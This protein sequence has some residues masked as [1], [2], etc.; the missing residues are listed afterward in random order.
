MRTIRAFQGLSVGFLI[1][2]GDCAKVDMQ[3]YQPRDN[4]CAGNINHCTSRG[5]R[6]TDRNNAPVLYSDGYARR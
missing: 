4:R 2:R 1:I 5:Q 3:I 6:L